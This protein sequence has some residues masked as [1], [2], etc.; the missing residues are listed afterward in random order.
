MIEEFVARR[1]EKENALLAI[2]VGG[3]VAGTVDII[4]A[5]LCYGWDLIVQISA[6]LVGLR[7]L[8][9]GF[10]Y[11]ALG[12]LLHFSIS[13]TFAAFYYVSSRKWTFLRDSWIVCG[14]AYG[15]GVQI[16]MMFLVLPF[17]T[18]TH[19]HG[20]YELNE[21]LIGLGAHMLLIGLPIAYSV[22]LFTRTA[23]DGG[24]VAERNSAMRG[25]A[26]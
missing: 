4:Y 26:A 12:L 16:V 10:G 13:L 2:V 17:L 22:R 1:S 15:A 18:S 11:Y 14:L 24:W 6:G 19:P 23:S 25:D 20:P 3:V 8:R 21:V 5:G 7:A 9:G